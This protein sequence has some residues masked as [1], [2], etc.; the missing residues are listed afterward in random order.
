MQI[1]QMTPAFSRFDAVGNDIE[2]IH[3]ALSKHY[4]CRL[5]AAGAKNPAIENIG[6]D[7]ALQIIQNQENLVIYHHSIE[8]KLIESILKNG[9]AKVVFRYHNVTPPCF[10]E[11]Y[12]RNMYNLCYTGEMQTKRLSEGYPGRFWLCDSKFNASTVPAATNVKIL[13]P[14]NMLDRWGSAA[15][16]A[17]VSAQ[18][19][20]NGKIN[21]LFVGRVVPNKGHKRL[22]EAVRC[23]KD[24]FGPDIH[25]WIVGSQDADMRIYA[26]ELTTYIKMQDL[27][28]QVSFIGQVNDNVL[29]AYYRGCDLFLCASEHEGFCVPVVEAQYFGLPV[30]AMDSTAVGETLGADQVLIEGSPVQFAAAIH[31]LANNERYRDYLAEKGRQNYDLR[32]KTSVLEK[33]LLDFI[34]NI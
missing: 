30:I 8:W 32:F 4:D 3:E 27:E 17:E 13:P 1:L 10:Y 5:H 24:T 2:L 29:T 23:Y 21:L 26:Y 6:I 9:K 18:L 31:V 12:S 11:N 16:D 19:R 7:R 25:L 33:Q 15:P 14:F 34:G 22:L 20:S 28:D